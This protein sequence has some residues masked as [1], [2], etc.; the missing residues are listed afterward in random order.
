VESRL[1]KLGFPKFGGAEISG[2]EDVP[3]MVVE[4]QYPGIDGEP[5]ESKVRLIGIVAGMLSEEMHV[6]LPEVQVFVSATS[7]GAC[8]TYTT[9]V[10]NASHIKLWLQVRNKEEED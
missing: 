7:P 1:Q 10:E 6:P 2:G 3:S 4:L 8:N 9:F 5:I